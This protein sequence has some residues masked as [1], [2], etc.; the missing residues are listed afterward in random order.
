MVQQSCAMAILGQVTILTRLT[1]PP[2]HSQPNHLVALEATRIM[3]TPMRGVSGY[4]APAE[5]A[6]YQVS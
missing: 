2:D 4:P 3:A 6:S 5:H 1:C